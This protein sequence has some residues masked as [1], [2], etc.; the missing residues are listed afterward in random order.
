MRRLGLTPPAAL[1]E[2]AR[3][4]ALPPI[5][6]AYQEVNGALNRLGSPPGP[7]D[8]PAERIINLKRILPEAANYAT[9]LLA[10]Y[11]LCAYSAQ[12]GNV[13]VAEQAGRLIRS[14]SWRALV[15]Q[16]V[17]EVKGGPTPKYPG[18]RA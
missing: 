13:D 10:E 6:K 15:N 9:R 11:H 17:N 14:L 1:R 7:A 8:T 18:W 16:K 2:W 5:E 12:E 3:L 4:A